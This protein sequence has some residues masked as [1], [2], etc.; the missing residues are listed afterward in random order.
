[1]RVGFSL[2]QIGN[3][4]GP[5]AVRTVAE[6]AEAVGYDS[7]WVV[8]RLLSPVLPKSPYPGKPDGKL[9]EGAK[10]VLD[11]I[12]T[13]VFAAACTTRARLGTSILN[14]P[15]YNPVLLARELTTLDVLSEGRL[16]VGFGTGWSEDEYDAAGVD[17]K[18]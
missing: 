3:L 7:L 16:V 6:R 11:P 13:L 8:D 15:Y 5:A 14:L 10:R 17:M 2:P 9:P 4:A 1:M 18:T 12:G